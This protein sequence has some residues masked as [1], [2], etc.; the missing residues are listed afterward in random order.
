MKQ[1]RTAEP[2]EAAQEDPVVTMLDVLFVS[3]QYGAAAYAEILDTYQGLSDDQRLKINALR[4]VQLETVETL[5]KH[6]HDAFAMEAPLSRRAAE[7]GK[8]IADQPVATWHDRMLRMEGI[9]VRAV[10]SYRVLRSL[11]GSRQPE[12][13]A[14]LLAMRLAMR[15]FARR[16]LD[17]EHEQSLPPVLRLLSPEAQAQVAAAG[18]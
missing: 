7:M 15:D 1:P 17:G 11:Y 18:T 16:E 13:C 2:R 10:E 6:L 14:K 4:L 9:C 3:E 12:L 5:R 8:A